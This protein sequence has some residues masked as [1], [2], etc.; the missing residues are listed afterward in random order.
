MNPVIVRTTSVRRSQRSPAWRRAV[1][2]R[3]SK[4][5]VG[6]IAPV[7]LLGRRC[8]H[9]HF[10]KGGS[11]PRISKFFLRLKEFRLGGKGRPPPADLSPRGPQAPAGYSPGAVLNTP[12][13]AAHHK[14]RVDH[15]GLPTPAPLGTRETAEKGQFVDY[16]IHQ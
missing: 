3:C 8:Q 4:H 6:P 7:Q 2:S 12:V 15:G 9:C 14:A 11:R 13:P 10:L 1:V 5:M 16:P